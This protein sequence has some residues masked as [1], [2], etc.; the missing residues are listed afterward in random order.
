[1]KKT[2]QDPQATPEGQ[3]AAGNFRFA[4]HP[5]GGQTSQYKRVL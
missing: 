2:S 4:D 5:E 3:R 1:V